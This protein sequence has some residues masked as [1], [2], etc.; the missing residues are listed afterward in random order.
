MQIKQNSDFNLS[1]ILLCLLPLI[2]HNPWI[3]RVTRQG[4]LISTWNGWNYFNLN[5]CEYS[6]IY[7]L[8]G[9]GERLI[10]VDIVLSVRLWNGSELLLTWTGRYTFTCGRRGC[11]ILASRFAK[12]SSTCCFIP[13]GHWNIILSMVLFTTEILQA[14]FLF[15][16]FLVL[17]S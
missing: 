2:I 7:W 1:L 13:G 5:V 3:I 4:K 11:F 10:Y 14:L 8:Q 9:N 15:N 12:K 17:V 16:I 6:H